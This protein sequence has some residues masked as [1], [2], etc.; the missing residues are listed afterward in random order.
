MPA[1]LLAWALLAAPLAAHAAPELGT[2]AQHQ[3]LIAFGDFQIF[4]QN[5][6]GNGVYLNNRLVF[7]LP[8]ETLVYIQPLPQPGRM[9]YLAR[10]N[11]EELRL[12]VVLGAGDPEPRVNRLGTRYYHVVL[13][14]DGVVYKKMYHVTNDST[15]VD[16]LPVSKTAD[17][18]ILGPG[19]LLFYHVAAANNEE[20]DGKTVSTF[21]M[22][23]HLV[24]PDGEQVRHLGYPI[25]NALPRL[26]MEW[27]DA[28]RISYRLSDGREGTLSV[29]QFQ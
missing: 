22:R 13:V 20:Q 23:L 26:D 5:R 14:I 3:G 11:Q 28:N 7:N 12:G 21:D 15:V 17:G 1:L 10:N 6:R 18:P 16:L 19:G 9:V 29:S 24:P 2:D 8:E 27:I 4:P 25:I